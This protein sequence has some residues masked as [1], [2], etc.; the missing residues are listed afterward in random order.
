MHRS[1]IARSARLGAALAAGLALSNLTAPPRAGAF[2][3]FYVGGADRS[4]YANATM[5]VLLRDGNRTVLSMQN[6]YEGPPEGFAM[7][8]PVPVVLHEDD[9]R[10]L[11]RELFARVDTLAAPRLVEY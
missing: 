10:T 6:D 11:P 2:C 4:L 9:V 8:V 3:G 1:M 7:V 5:V